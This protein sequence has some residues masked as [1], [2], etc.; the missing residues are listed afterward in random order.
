M[1]TVPI[2][3]TCYDAILGGKGIQEPVA[4]LA[5][6]FHEA[7]VT[8]VL[9]VTLPRVLHAEQKRGDSEYR[10]ILPYKKIIDKSHLNALLKYP[11]SANFQLK[12]IF[13]NSQNTQL[14]IPMTSNICLL[15]YGH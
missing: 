13:V 3:K 14:K 12:L 7:P 1:A 2:C 5:C 10:I 9:A 8:I 15:F 6:Q 4:M 11:R